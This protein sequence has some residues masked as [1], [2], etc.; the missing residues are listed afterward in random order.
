[1]LQNELQ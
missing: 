1:V